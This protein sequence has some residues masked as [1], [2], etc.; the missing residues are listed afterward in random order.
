MQKDPEKYQLEVRRK[1]IEYLQ[2]GK[3]PKT[4]LKRL[5]QKPQTFYADVESGLQF[6]KTVNDKPVYA[7]NEYLGED[8]TREC[9]NYFNQTT[10]NDWFEIIEVDGKLIVNSILQLKQSPEFL[11]LEADMREDDKTKG[12]NA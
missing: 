1:F 10:F 7:A 9:F 5:H 8:G 11:I 2:D 3:I 12:I 6:H 4:E